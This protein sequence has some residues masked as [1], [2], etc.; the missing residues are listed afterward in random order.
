MRP[1]SLK[2]L[3]DD[4]AAAKVLFRGWK[5]VG[6]RQHCRNRAA[7]R[8]AAS[9]GF[10]LVET[11][12]ALALGALL[13][14]FVIPNLNYTMIHWRRGQGASDWQDQWMQAIMRLTQELDEALPLMVGDGD[15]QKL[16]FNGNAQSLTFVRLTRG[17]TGEQKLKTIHISVEHDDDGD[18]LRQSAQTFD[19]EHFSDSQDQ[20][21]GMV[22]FE[23]P[24]QLSFKLVEA[25]EPSNSEKRPPV[26]NEDGPQRD[27]SR[28]D[29]PRGD[30]ARPNGPPLGRQEL[31]QRIVLSAIP[32]APGIKSMPPLVLPIVAR[33]PMKRAENGQDSQN[34]QD[35]PPAP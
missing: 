4:P 10:T 34:G 2:R 21:G 7:F 17:V 9:G 3:I 24:Y 33:R 14:S 20:S 27:G 25:P 22:L 12:V 5:P 28:P 23:G 8:H 18:K 29:A 35:Q 11:I 16:A 19:A 31:P 30:R 13:L 1:S 6:T 26:P 32:A 15:A